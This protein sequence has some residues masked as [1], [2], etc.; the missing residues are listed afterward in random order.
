VAPEYS[1]RVDSPALTSL[2]GSLPLSL[3]VASQHVDGGTEVGILR[4]I[5]AFLR[6]FFG[7]RA[8]LAAENL[9]LRQ[10]LLVLQRSVKRPELRKRDRIFWSW[11]SRLTCIAFCR[12]IS[13]TITK[14]ARICRW[15]GIPRL[16]EP[17]S[18]PRKA[19]LWPRPTSAGCITA[20]RERPDL[21]RGGIGGGAGVL[22]A[23]AMI[24]PTS[25]Y[26]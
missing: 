8:A 22:Y 25:C 14:P 4:L 15:S 7:S 17:C 1:V 3:Y 10:Q 19:R 18:H 23:Q 5:L 12:S 13:A 21:A 2:A 6:A 20:I 16:H 11:L 9:S 26:S 24:L